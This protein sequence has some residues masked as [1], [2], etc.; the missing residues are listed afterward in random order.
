MVFVV[1]DGLDASG[2]STQAFKLYNF[3]KNHGKTVYLRFHPSS[4]N[5]FGV[6]AKQFL[7]LK[8]KGA[9]F[10]AAFF[11]MLDVI[12]SIPLYSWRKYDYVIFVRYLMGTAYLPSPLHR[13][14]YHFFA[15]LVPTS[16]L[17]FF[18]DVNPEEAYRRIQQERKRQEMFESLEELKRIR[19]KA[20][21]L[22][23]IDK[24]TI[25]DANKPVKSV[26]KEIRK[27]L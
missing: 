26:E 3:L 6:K 24:W 10:A 16:N 18:L 4:D 17:M 13:I 2:K 20:L 11:Y 5:F 12:R 27:S 22:A 8:G 14:A 21:S 1:I 7:Y 9:H 15:S 23:S 25:I 19:R